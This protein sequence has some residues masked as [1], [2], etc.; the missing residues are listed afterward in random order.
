[1]KI[2]M[3]A[4]FA[5]VA[6]MA[7][8]DPLE[9]MWKTAA[10]DNGNSGLIEVVVCGDALCGT[11]IKAFDSNG[12]PRESPNVGRKLIWDTH[13]TGDGEY[14]GMVYSPDRDVEYKSK[15]VLTGDSLSVSGCRFGICREG[16]VW[17]RQ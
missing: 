3:A 13:P 12:A 7:Q 6:G 15:L 17:S 1:M 4:A 2:W 11:L 14:R 16:G 8:A 10:D 5:M 9:G